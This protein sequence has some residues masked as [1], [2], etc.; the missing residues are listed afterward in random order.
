[1]S[2]R[3]QTG[4]VYDDGIGLMTADQ[5]VKLILLPVVVAA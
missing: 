2:A 1:V 5:R 3:L 4:V